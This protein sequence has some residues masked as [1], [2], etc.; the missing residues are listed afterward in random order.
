M[1]FWWFW[2]IS[3]VVCLILNEVIS[4]ALMNRIKRE[5]PNA[6]IKIKKKSFAEK[7]TSWLKTFLFACVPFVNIVITILMLFA[8]DS[9]KIF[10]S[11]DYTGEE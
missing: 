6:K 11:K 5:N 1:W 8:I 4:I 10:N 3:T 9:I 7:F 2:G